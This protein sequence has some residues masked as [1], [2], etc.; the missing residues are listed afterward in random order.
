MQI[1]LDWVER[2]SRL[3]PGVTFEVKPLDTEQYL[4]LNEIMARNKDQGMAG[5]AAFY[6]EAMHIAREVFPTCLRNLR[7][8]QVRTEGMP[9]DITLEELITTPATMSL[10]LDILTEAS[11]ASTIPE[12]DVKNSNGRLTATGQAG[13]RKANN[14]TSGVQELI[15]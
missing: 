3:F 12:A 11:L 2:K 7:G 15:G 6:K 13:E 8:V 4:R 5:Q 14:N 9:L 10:V 1:N